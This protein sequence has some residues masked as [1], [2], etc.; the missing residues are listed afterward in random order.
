MIWEELK[1]ALQT[2]PEI[3]ALGFEGL[4]AR[5]LE[6][7]LNET[8]V[9]A[10]TGDQPS[11]DAHNLQ[12][13]VCVQAKCYASDSV[14]N[15]KQI[16][17]DFDANLRALPNTDIYV[18][19]IT[20]TTTQ[21]D[22]TLSAMRDKSGVDVI[23]LSFGN[24]DSALPALCVEFWEQLQAFDCI[25]DLDGKY[26]SEIASSRSTASH[27]KRF[28]LLKQEFQECTQTFT[29]TH[30]A[31]QAYL[32]RRFGVATNNLPLSLPIELTKAVRRAAYEEKI[33][34]WWKA[35]NAKVAIIS[36]KEGM[37]KTWLAAQCAQRIDQ[38]SGGLVLW[39]DS[40]HWRACASVEQVV[41][42]ALSRLQLGDVGKTRRLVR[43][44][45]NQ[46]SPKT[47][48]ILDGVNERGALDAAQKI[49][50]D[51]IQ[52][53]QGKCRI[54]F[55]TRP[56]LT[57]SRYEQSLWKRWP[58][59]LV[60]QFDDQE[61]AAV[62]ATVTPPIL[63]SD[64]P[65]KVIPFA[66]IPRYF[67]TC[68]QL[69]D[70]L[71]SFSNISL[72]LVLWTD[73]LNKIGG[74][75]PQINEALGFHAQADAVEILIKLATLS[76]TPNKAGIAQDLL[77]RCFAGKYS[78]VR[79]YLIELRIM[80]RVGVFEATLSE[81]HT[82][83]GR[84]LFLQQL[85]ATLPSETVREMADRLV[86]ELEPL[87]GDDGAAEALFVALQLSAL[88]EATTDLISKRR[89]SLIYAWLFCHNSDAS[90]ARLKFWCEHDILAYILFT[91]SFFEQLY[92]G[93]AQQFIVKPLARL[94]QSDLNQQTFLEQSLKN[95]LLLTWFEGCHPSPAEFEHKGHKLPIAKTSQQVRLAAVAL[96]ILSLR[97][98]NSF[99]RTL[100]ICYATNDLTWKNLQGRREGELHKH[101]FKSIQ[102]NIGIL[103]RWGFTERIMPELERL[104]NANSSDKLLIDGL[105]HLAREVR[106]VEI[107]ACLQLSPP[108]AKSSYWGSSATDL[109]RQK[110]RL[111]VK[112][113]DGMFLNQRE[114][115]H[116][117]VRDD[118]PALHPEDVT[119]IVE[120]LEKAC[121]SHAIAAGRAQ[122]VEDREL[123][124]WLPWYAKHKQK[125]LSR[126]AGRLQLK[127]LE[128]ENSCGMFM[129]LEGIAISLSEQDLS[130]WQ[131]LYE[132]KCRNTAV[133][134]REIDFTVVLATEIV[135]LSMPDELLHGWLIIAA[136]NSAKRCSLLHG[137]LDEILSLRIQPETINFA[138]KQCLESEAFFES[139][140]KNTIDELEFWCY[141]AS[142]TVEA[143]NELFVWAANRLRLTKT[144]QKR[145]FYL[146]RLWLSSAP[147]AS[148]EAEINNLGVES[149]FDEQAIHAWATIGSIP[150][151]HALI[152][153][154]YDELMRRVPQGFAGSIFFQ[155]NRSA[156]LKRW[157]EEI[158]GLAT[159]NLSK[160]PFNRQARGKT[161][162]VLDKNQ[163]VQW[164]SLDLDDTHSRA[165][166][167]TV[168]SWGVNYG[169][170]KD[171][172]KDMLMKSK[173][174]R[175]QEYDQERKRWEQDVD[176]F[177]KWEHCDLHFFTGWR[178]LEAYSKQERDQ[179]E[180]QAKALL[181]AAMS[182]PH[183]QFHLGG[184]LY[185]V[186]SCLLP[187]SPKE[188][189][190]YYLAFHSGSLGITVSSNLNVP[191]FHM[192][193]W[194][195]NS[196]STTAHDELRLH[197]FEQ[198]E[199]EFEIMVLVVAAM[200]NSA[201][202]QL[203]EMAERLLSNEFAKNRALGVS[204]LA[205][206]GSEKSID[207][208]GKL[209]TQDPSAWVRWHA[210]W[211]SEVSLQEQ[212]AKDHF[213]K[214]LRE[215]DPLK[216]SAKLQV[217]KPA[218]TP[219]ARWWMSLIKNEEE[220]SG[221]MLEGKSAAIIASF[222]HH[223]NSTSSNH[224]KV[225]GLTLDEFCRG[226]H[227]D[228]LKTQRLF[229]W[230]N[231]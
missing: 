183:S 96:S 181:L 132:A 41:T 153:L 139:P 53:E 45:R 91:E 120:A 208:L 227:L 129:L 124:A 133:S 180:Q 86:K 38:E 87:A 59:V 2:M 104:A 131:N 182:A 109:I 42:E 29:S 214:A 58:E 194:N 196:C 113:E 22:D 212:Q 173:Q 19:A 114:F 167:S 95:W 14:P 94:W 163:V 25:K 34:Q 144:P 71:R 92:D 148:L 147:L 225:N 116:L 195:V 210:G 40:L 201:T 172:W 226:E 81:A 216:L 169:A 141:V 230:W 89:A 149:L 61:F 63:R 10:R 23:V 222:C 217:L 211:A 55:T 18:L 159:K 68:V 100:A 134:I 155:S 85:L 65:E 157:G 219:L 13:N 44:V 28:E 185:A 162:I 215:S 36:G 9:L 191:E 5:F 112:S 209:Q 32:Q 30:N 154:S 188:V 93:D 146:L 31:A 110:R 192:R 8:F 165:W 51:L 11:G 128:R 64:I 179:F 213:R 24:E 164:I 57:T 54:L 115:G 202:D 151:N 101:E 103:M 27:K 190:R 102:S 122:T 193:L 20:R 80:E 224:V 66:R 142:L 118:L 170:S 221:L 77:N 223:W 21:L 12:R 204:M 39:L 4:V 117:A 135:L 218:L 7:L 98:E 108:D 83:L 121:E 130:K 6:L 184:F 160:P 72:A 79:H 123:Q 82:T 156:D 205:Y 97:P 84:A 74:L 106:I 127:A 228:K 152:K 75:E 16:E 207:R 67:Q 171:A 231:F 56:L 50:D 46:W 88:Q 99:L 145:N 78:E 107:P 1:K 178:A 37:G 48:I 62:L 198:C 111:F 174:E 52:K 199:N 143:N 15:A 177:E 166:S 138:V 47:L 69:R 158:F 197:L 90:D 220:K 76:P 161:R 140:S 206:I 33:Q 3:G 70:K 176:A 186:I 43:K 126:L 125:H 26:K 60:E 200:A 35:A 73:L 175:Q 49:L 229:P 168:S 150:L 137:P 203:F 136:K 187:H 105:C 189:Y 17:G 119:I